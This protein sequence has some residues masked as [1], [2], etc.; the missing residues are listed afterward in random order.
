VT[1]AGRGQ[2]VDVDEEALVRIARVEGQHAVVDVFLDALALVARCQG[3]AR[4]AREQTGLHSLGLRV[5][6]HVLDDNTPFSLDVDGAHRSGVQ[7]LG[8]ADVALTAD[9]VALLERR[10]VVVGVVESALLDGGQSVDSVVSRLVGN[11]GVFLQNQ[12]VVFDGVL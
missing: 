1:R 12:R 10:A 5:V 2:L 3:A 11:V 8:R 7:H 4:S 6:G 9:P